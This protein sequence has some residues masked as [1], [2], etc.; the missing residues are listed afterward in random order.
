[1]DKIFQDL[2]DIIQDNAVKM[3]LLADRIEQLESIGG[4]SG[5]SASIEDYESGKEYKRNVLIVDTTTETVY[6]VLS[7]YTSTTI[8]DDKKNGLIKLVGFESQLV[9]FNHDPSQTE[10]NTLPM[11][12]VVTIYSSTDDPYEP[13]LSGD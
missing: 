1:M 13:I 3:K 4:D 9:S 5:G 8:E 6:R 10:I 11:D 7:D 2:V 12:T